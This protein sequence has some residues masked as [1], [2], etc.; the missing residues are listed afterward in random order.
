MAMVSVKINPKKDRKPVLLETGQSLERLNKDGPLSDVTRTLSP[1]WVP[2]ALQDGG[3]F[4]VHPTHKDVLQ[5]THKALKQEREATGTVSAYDTERSAKIEML[6]ER[7]TLEAQ[8]IS[9]WRR[10]H[11]VQLLR[12]KISRQRTSIKY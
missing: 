8:P 5:W 2:Y 10:K 9:E 1:Q 11:M 12:E 4:F 3:V 6:M 7:N